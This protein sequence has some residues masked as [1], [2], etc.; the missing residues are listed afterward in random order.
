MISSSEMYSDAA[1]TTIANA[2]NTNN[3]M[4][5]TLKI[6]NPATAIKVEVTVD[7]ESDK[8]HDTKDDYRSGLS[9]VLEE[10][11]SMPDKAPVEYGMAM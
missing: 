3:T 7:H 9:S 2:R 8:M 4:L 11:E 10:D 6:I 1:T 5:T